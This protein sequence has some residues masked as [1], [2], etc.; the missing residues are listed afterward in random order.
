[1]NR[2]LALGVAAVLILLLLV[3]STTYT[4]AFHE[5]AIVKTFG[6]STPESVQ[7]SPGLKLKWPLVQDKAKF[8]TRLQVVESSQEEVM[9]ADGQQVV[10]KAFLL[11]S[12]DTATPEATLAFAESY[13]SVEQAAADLKSPFVAALSATLS[14]YRFED[15]MGE[16]HK[17]A[18]IEARIQS[19]LQQR[20][21]GR[22]VVPAVVG[23]SQLILPERA[24]TSVVERMQATRSG[25]AEAVRQQGAAAAEGIKSK[26]ATEAEKIR[27]FATE[28]A[29]EIRAQS[30]GQ[31][32]TYIGMM[33]EEESLAIFLA[34]LDALE[35]SL[36]EGVTALL[37][38]DYAP[39]HLMRLSSRVD[40]QG[41]PQDH[42]FWQRVAET[43]PAAAAQPLLGAPPALPPD[44]AAGA[45]ADGGN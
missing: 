25:M 33:S 35:A 1:M 5:V 20:V 28:R 43:A 3:F 12:I 10:A 23:I 30:L 36:S 18:V 16:E 42:E 2:L 14:E 22:G 15:L 38:A 45:G 17:L 26:A 44:A 13:E 32:A 29:A 11:W 4:V 39:W 6:R 40:Q 37:D 19:A 9:L 34:W 41:I 27:A 31:A 24:T 8:D 21:A 7:T